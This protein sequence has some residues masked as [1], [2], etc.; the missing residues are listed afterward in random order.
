MGQ[1]LLVVR[2]TRQEWSETGFSIAGIYPAQRNHTHRV[3]RRIH[4]EVYCAK[5]L[6][7]MVGLRPVFRARDTKPAY[8]SCCQDE[9]QVIQG[10]IKA[11]CVHSYYAAA[12]RHILSGE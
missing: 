3:H 1:Q 7:D 8:A 5:R 6:L 10:A 12:V 11:S 2:E 4:Q 9:G